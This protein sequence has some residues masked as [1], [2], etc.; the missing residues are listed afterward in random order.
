MNKHSL[1]SVDATVLLPHKIVG[2]GRR[3]GKV[4]ED[5]RNAP[6]DHSKSINPKLLVLSL[7]DYENVS[8]MEKFIGNID[9][10]GFKN[11]FFIF[12]LISFF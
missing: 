7:L 4:M 1:S 5:S 2:D 3:M 10:N 9:E 8:F 6:L 11:K 12:Y